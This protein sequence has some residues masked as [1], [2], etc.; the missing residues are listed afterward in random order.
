MK[1]NGTPYGGDTP[2]NSN[3]YSASRFS[4]ASKSYHSRS[5]SNRSQHPS[6]NFMMN[7]QEFS[8]NNNTQSEDLAS[9]EPS[10]ERKARLA[11]EEADKIMEQ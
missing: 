8:M 2:D 5:R 4:A 11:K 6:V 3:P 7:A 1:F 9:I 10:S